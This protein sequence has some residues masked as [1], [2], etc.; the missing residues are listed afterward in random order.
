M[1]N[2]VLITGATGGIGKEFAKLFAQS[3]YNLA[4][5]A[6]NEKEL[7]QLAQQ[8]VTQ[9]H[10]KVETFA[11]DLSNSESSTKLVTALFKKEIAIEIL[12]NNA[13]FGTSGKFWEIPS[14]IESN[15]IELNIL[16]LTILT[17]LLLPGM[18]S[19]KS[20]RIL[21]VASVAAFLPGPLM[22]VYYASKAYVLSFSVALNE[23]LKGTGIS[24]SALCPGPTQTGFADRAKLTTSKLF[25]QNLSTAVDVAQI[26]FNGLMSGKPIILCDLQSQIMTKFIQLIPRT[27]AAKIAKH[28][29]QS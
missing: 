20:G 14:S 9:Y 4:L 3:G 27:W 7:Q 18:V 6:R 23:E 12:V 13:G 2:Y 21:N 8:L 10:I 16:N 24:V 1:S 28:A 26:G 29:N 22:A 19:R 15:E 25:S 17:K 5:V 11:F